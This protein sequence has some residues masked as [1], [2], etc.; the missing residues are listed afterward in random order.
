MRL[1]L[2]AMDVARIY[3]K[4]E[5]GRLAEKVHRV[6]LHGERLPQLG[7]HRPASAVD[8]M[9]GDSD[10][11]NLQKKVRAAIHCRNCEN[12]ERVAVPE[13]PLIIGSYEMVRGG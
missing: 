9:T 2:V 11:H 5:Q 12:G 10:F 13:L 3:A 1:D 6:T 8:M 4:P 7:S